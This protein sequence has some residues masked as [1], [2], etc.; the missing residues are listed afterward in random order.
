VTEYLQRR[1][2]GA[3]LAIGL[4]AVSAPSLAATETLPN[5]VS[6]VWLERD[7]HYHFDIRSGA[8]ANQLIV[9][10]PKDLQFPGSRA[11]ILTRTGPA[12]FACKEAPNR[13][14]VTVSFKSPTRGEL[15]MAGA[16]S[17]NA[18]H[19]GTWMA[20]NDFTLVRP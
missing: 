7:V 14:K 6:G 18:P 10:L 8:D 15:K 4:V 3:L 12:S 5:A 13:P 20:V 16:G 17:T 9:T 19:G 1:L 2:G 11:F